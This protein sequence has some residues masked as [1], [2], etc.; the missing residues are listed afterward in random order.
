MRTRDH[1]FRE[2]S[3][4]TVTWGATLSTTAAFVEGD[5]RHAAA[6]PAISAAWAVLA[7]AV[8]KSAKA[9]TNKVLIQQSSFSSESYGLSD[10]TQD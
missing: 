1:P 6:E 9:A 8:M 7:H 5:A 2:P 3:T 10:Y 4:S